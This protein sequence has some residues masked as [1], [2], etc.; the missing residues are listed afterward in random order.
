MSDTERDPAMAQLLQTLAVVKRMA[1]VTRSGRYAEARFETFKPAT[2]KQAAALATAERFTRAIPWVTGD[3]GCSNLWFLGLPGLGKTHL[4]AAVLHSAV[5]E[6]LEEGGEFAHAFVSHAELM[7]EWR[8][9]R[10]THG[11]ETAFF[12]RYTQQGILVLDDIKPAR[13]DEEAE[14]FDWLVELRYRHPCRPIVLTANLNQADLREALGERSFDRLRE[15]ALLA[16]LDGSSY[17]ARFG[18]D[19]ASIKED[20]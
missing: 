19:G 14:A 9:A 8:Q 18:W 16:V 4:A 1:N 13:T 12:D 6:D 2:K 5:A 20:A 10:K 17:R 3:L 11:T 15:G 7:R